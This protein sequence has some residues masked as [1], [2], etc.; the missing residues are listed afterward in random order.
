MSSV[1][2]NGGRA[3]SA[4]IL[5][6]LLGPMNTGHGATTD[7]INYASTIP[8]TSAVSPGLRAPDLSGRVTAFLRVLSL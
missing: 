2:R 3:L 7:P 4:G 1:T 5:A 8:T 6:Q